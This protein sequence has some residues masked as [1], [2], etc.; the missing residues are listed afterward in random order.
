MTHQLTHPAPAISTVLTRS[1][2]MY[3]L[4]WLHKEIERHHDKDCRHCWVQE[5]VGGVALFTD[6]ESIVDM[7]DE[8]PD[9]NEQRPSVFSK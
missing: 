6:C 4:L 8:E 7:G 2:P 3:Y 5:V 1:G 9:F